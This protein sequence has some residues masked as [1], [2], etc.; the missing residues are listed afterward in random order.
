M[1]KTLRLVVSLYFIKFKGIV[2]E[3]GIKKSILI[4]KLLSIKIRDIAPIGS[5]ELFI[6]SL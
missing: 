5:I 6:V 3:G 2:L 1:D 4:I